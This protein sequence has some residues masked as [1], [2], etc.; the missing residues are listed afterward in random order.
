MTSDRLILAVDDEPTLLRLVKTELSPRGFRVLTASSGEHA[1]RLVE[2]HR[3]ELILLD[4]MMP[5][6]NGWEILRAVQERWTTPI[7]MLSVQSRELDTI[8]GL[9]MGADDYVV[10]PFAPDELAARIG[11]V[12]RRAAGIKGNEVVVADGVRIDLARRMV[13]GRD[14]NQV[15]LTRTEWQLLETLAVNAGKVLLN[16]ELLTKVWGPEYRNDLH[17]LR[18]W[19]SR[20]RQKIETEPSD[21]T[22][23]ETRRGIGYAF[24]DNSK[25]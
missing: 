13:V 5:G 1:L 2:E 7:V 12:L 19:I 6:M 25:A 22:I 24:M 15:R 10:K 18:I 3:P 4:V 17:Y 8:R 9:E 20:L 11:A 14:G 23:I 16:Q 21:P